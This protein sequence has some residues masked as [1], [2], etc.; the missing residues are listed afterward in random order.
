[1]HVRLADEAGRRILQ[2]RPVGGEALE[3]VVDAAGWPKTK[4]FMSDDGSVDGDGVVLLMRP[5]WHRERER[6]NAAV[7]LSFDETLALDA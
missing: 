2:V 7:K 5:R 3:A 6:K 1:M 4:L